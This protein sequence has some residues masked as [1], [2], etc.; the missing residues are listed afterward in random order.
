M[1]NSNCPAKLQYL[2]TA[3]SAA[4]RC[5]LSFPMTLL[6]GRRHRGAQSVTPYLPDTPS[7]V[8]VLLH[9]KLMTAG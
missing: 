1:S 3:I 8:C 6:S 4:D 9:E 2:A 5:N 7:A